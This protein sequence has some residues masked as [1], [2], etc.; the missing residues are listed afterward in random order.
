MLGTNERIAALTGGGQGGIHD[1]L[2]PR[3]EVYLRA[4][5]HA[6]LLGQHAAHTLGQRPP[7]EV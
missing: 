1:P 4:A 7:I 3:T 2:G 6:R 5:R